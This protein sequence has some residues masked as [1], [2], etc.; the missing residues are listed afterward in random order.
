MLTVSKKLDIVR[1]KESFKVY[2]L[3][4]YKNDEKKNQRN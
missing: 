3:T 1:K 4:I 2:D